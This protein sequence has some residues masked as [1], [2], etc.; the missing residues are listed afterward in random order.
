MGNQYVCKN[1]RKWCYCRGSD[2]AKASERGKW[3]I[4]FHSGLQSTQHFSSW[5]KICP[6]SWEEET[7]H[8]HTIWSQPKIHKK[9][10]FG[11]RESF[12]S[13]CHD[14][15]MPT[16]KTLS[17]EKMKRFPPRV[18]FFGILSALIGL[19]GPAPPSTR[20]PAKKVNKK[21]ALAARLKTEQQQRAENEWKIVVE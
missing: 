16:F 1:G 18:G 17:L 21:C 4:M 12:Q 11:T 14:Y 15:M 7:T 2:D 20:P 9:F 19:L 5:T 3:M 8:F 13:S 10:Y 6:G